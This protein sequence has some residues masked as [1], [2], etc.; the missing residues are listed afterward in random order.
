MNTIKA[1]LLNR[2][3]SSAKSRP[4]EIVKILSLKPGQKIADVGSGGGHFSL[5]FARYVGS[6]GKVYATDTNK[7][8]L[9]FVSNSSEKSDF[10]N[11]VTVL[12]EGDRFPFT[13]EKLDL[14]FLRNVYHH[15]PNR[16][17]YFRD[18]A[19]ALSTGTRVAIIDYDGR[20]KWSFHRLF[21]HSV[22]KET[23]INEMAVA[24]YCLVE[25]HTFL[26]E[27]SFLIFSAAN[28]KKNC[29]QEGTLF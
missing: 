12:A 20:G 17:V 25:D 21:C 10:H 6:E 27:Q 8:F 13:N 2:K 1:R 3:A 7:G 28:N 29:N 23:I 11:I 19:A 4:D 14:V 26:P 24:G 5:L 16:E 22:P 15:L 18:L 9:D